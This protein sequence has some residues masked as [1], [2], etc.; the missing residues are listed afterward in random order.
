VCGSA[1]TRLAGLGGSLLLLRWLCDLRGMGLR[2]KVL[3]AQDC[4]HGKKPEDRKRKSENQRLKKSLSA[5]ARRRWSAYVVPA[6]FFLKLREKEN[7]GARF[8]HSY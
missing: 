6:K 2:R 4:R 5:Q 8:Q 3:S 1:A 7:K